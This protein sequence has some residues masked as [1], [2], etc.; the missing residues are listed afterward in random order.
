[1][2]AAAAAGSR[3]STGIQIPSW[4]APTR[5]AWRA[6]VALAWRNSDRWNAAGSPRP[7][8]IIREGVAPKRSIQTQSPGLAL[9]W[10]CCR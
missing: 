5:V 4:R 10:R 2:A 8:K 1:M 9:N 7:I 3:A 6:A